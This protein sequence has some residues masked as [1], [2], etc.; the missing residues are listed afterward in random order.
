MLFVMILVR[1]HLGR[2]SPETAFP[3]GL[4]GPC[5]RERLT[6]EVAAY[7]NDTN[8]LQFN[9]ILLIAAFLSMMR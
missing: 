7:M 6:P 3:R 9:V 2:L 1:K 4:V 5:T 8:Q